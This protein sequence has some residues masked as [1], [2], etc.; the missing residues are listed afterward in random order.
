MAN[1]KI[2]EA[3]RHSAEKQKKGEEKIKFGLDHN[4]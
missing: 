4:F 2:G 1:K 3:K